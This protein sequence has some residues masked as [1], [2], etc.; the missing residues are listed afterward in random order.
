MKRRG[1]T[2]EMTGM[3]ANETVDCGEVGNDVDL[4]GGETWVKP[5]DETKYTAYQKSKGSKSNG[6][7]RS[8]WLKKTPAVGKK[9]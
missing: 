9:V 6:R 8:Q 7:A 1:K 5:N 3:Y 2:A 4:K